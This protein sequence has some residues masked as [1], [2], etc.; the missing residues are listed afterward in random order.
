MLAFAAGL[1]EA[2][3]VEFALVVLFEFAV[4]LQLTPKAASIVNVRKT[5]LRRIYQ[6]LPCCNSPKALEGQ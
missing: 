3:T 4:G 1:G 5:I 6:F 2:V